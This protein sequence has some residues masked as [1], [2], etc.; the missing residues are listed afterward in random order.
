MQVCTMVQET[1]GY[2]EP[3]YLQTSQ[4]NEKSDL[5]VEL[6]TGQNVIRFNKP[7]AERSLANYFLYAVQE[8][9]LVEGL[10]PR[11]V[12]EGTVEL[13]QSVADIARCCLSLKGEERPNMKQV[14]IELEGLRNM[15]V[16]RH[17][18]PWDGEELHYGEET[19]YLLG[20]GAENH[21]SIR[22]Q[23]VMPIPAGR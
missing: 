4:L 21:D 3:E 15:G 16:G 14:A 20:E 18:S 5:L 6:L 7:E 9:R 13:L 17:F 1:L 10:E 2:L 8:N 11:V 23:A 19:V 12:E 22:N